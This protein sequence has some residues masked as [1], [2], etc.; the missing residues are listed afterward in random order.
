MLC[1][2]KSSIAAS[3][4]RIRNDM[5]TKCCF[6]RGLWSV[7]LCDTATWNATNAQ[8]HIQGN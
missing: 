3:T 5:E 6:T 2:N 8:C 1:I 4:L 7:D